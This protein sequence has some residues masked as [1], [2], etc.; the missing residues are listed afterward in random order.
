MNTFTKFL[1][2][3]LVGTLALVL[4]QGLS[5]CTDNGV[6]LKRVVRVFSAGDVD[7]SSEVALARFF[8][9]YDEYTND[10]ANESQRE[11]FRTAFRMVR[12]NYVSPTDPGKMVDDALKGVRKLDPKPGGEAPRV[13]V[14]AALHSMLSSLD[15]HSSYLNPDEY[16]ESRILTKGRFGGLG[17]E[18]TMKN[19]VLK[20]ISPIEGTPA[21]RAGIRAGDVITQVDGKS[22]KGVSLT[23]AVKLMR[24]RPGSVIVLGIARAGLPVFEVRIRRAVIHMRSVRWREEGNIAYVRVVSFTEQ[25][26]PKLKRAMHDLFAHASRL[27]VKLKGIV[28]DL[29]NNPGGLL[30]QSLFVSDSFLNGGKIVSIRERNPRHDR[31]FMAEPGDLSRGLPMVVLINEGSASASE[32][33]ASALKD[34]KRAVI[35]GQRSFGKGS[36]QTIQPL[37]LEGALRLTIARYYAP[38]GHTIQARGVVP[39][40]VLTRAP[41]KDAG[42]KIKFRREVDMPGALPGDHMSDK[43][44]R[45]T[46]ASKSCPAAG[47]QGKDRELGCALAYLH[48]GAMSAFLAAVTA[49]APAL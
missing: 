31:V 12:A 29:R 7:A 27:G 47:P 45:A 23:Q 43:A 17:I 18:V 1:P 8:K 32:I 41:A 46:V 25:V 15:P 30:D 49:S 35:M 6:S 33:V 40:I 19:K 26:E 36:V 21:F 48:A 37:P 11:Q 38:S 20:V 13:L 44:A 9:V 34:Q 2:F 3:V 22:L 28:L 16:R 42:K 10:P 14:D 5:G 4:L 24:G 39:D